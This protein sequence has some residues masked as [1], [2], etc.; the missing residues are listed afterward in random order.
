MDKE[1]SGLPDVHSEV[2][3][4]ESKVFFGPLDESNERF[5]A[6]IYR[7]VEVED[8]STR[9][10]TPA[11]ARTTF[12]A[13]LLEV[14][15]MPETLWKA[16]SS[17]TSASEI[18]QNA[19]DAAVPPFAFKR[20]GSV[21]TFAGMVDSNIFD[22]SVDLKSVEEVAIEELTQEPEG[23]REIVELFNRALYRHLETRGL[24]VDKLKK[25]AYFPRADEGPRT[26]TYQA[27]FRQ[28]TRTVTKPVV[29]KRTSQVLPWEHEAVSFGFERLGQEWAL[30]ILPSYVF[31][32]DGKDTYLHYSR[33]GALATRKAARDFNM[34]VYNDLVFWTSMLSGGRDRIDVDLGGDRLLTIR[35][36]LSSCELELP[37]AD[38]AEIA[39]SMTQ[40]K[41][42][43]LERLE[44]EM[45]EAAELENEAETKRANA[46]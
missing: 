15:G 23:R 11:R 21:L 46:D 18:Y 5:R 30:R 44:T 28:A 41:D 38:P 31:T 17:C 26:I 7:R 36:L 42:P 29:S 45:L 10:A 39:E 43:R 2:T 35:G 37:P 9:T 34:Q 3:K 14:V 27:S 16:N 13:N 22:R 12:F 40:Y 32:K 25:R 8:V 1:G 19:G 4:N 20:G 6:L 24:V 33:I